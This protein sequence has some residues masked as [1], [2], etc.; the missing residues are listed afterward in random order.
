[1]PTAA[2]GSPERAALEDELTTAL[3]QE[4]AREVRAS[5]AGFVLLMTP[6]H[7]ERVDL[8]ALRADRIEPR[9]VS[10]PAGIR[11]SQIRFRND[12]HLNVLGHR[13]FAEGLAPLVEA[14]LR[15]LPRVG[16]APR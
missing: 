14:E 7:S 12:S 15:A 6:R 3:L 1:M 11:A 9:F 16:A 10:L 5:G 2:P 4:L 13:Q 8:R